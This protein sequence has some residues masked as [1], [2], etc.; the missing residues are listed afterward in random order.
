LPED[1]ELAAK[2]EVRGVRA[3]YYYLLLDWFGN[4]PVVTSFTDSIM[5][6]NS[7]RAQV[8]DFVENELTEIV[9]YLQPTVEYGRVTQNVCNTLLGRLYINSEGFIG[10]PRWQDCID[11]CNEVSGYQL[12]EN[13]LENFLTENELSSEIIFAI[14]YDR[15]EGTTGNY[16]PSLTFHYNQWQAISASASGWTWSVNGICAQPGVYSSFEEGDERIACM[17]EGIQMSVTGDTIKDRTGAVLNYTEDIEEFTDAKEYEGVRLRKMELKEGEFPER[18]HDLVVM[19]Y[20][21]VLMMKAESYYRLGQESQ[22]R[23]LVNQIRGRSGLDPVDEVDEDV[24]DMEWLHEFLFEGIR[25]SVNIRFGTYFQPWWAKP[26]ITPLEKAIF[27]IPETEL[28]K[29]SNLQQNPGY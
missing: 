1:E 6:A 3:Y 29:N 14:P 17:E 8:Y 13:V 23:S 22:A 25:R 20:A 21:E 7:P 15:K 5:P 28:V 24:L 11:A 26:S 9:E 4:V 10:T 27:P 19:R 16:L 12:T 18:D 2:A